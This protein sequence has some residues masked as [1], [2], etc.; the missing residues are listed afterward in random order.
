VGKLLSRWKRERVT[1]N[2]SGENA[3]TLQEF[4]GELGVPLGRVVDQAL[5]EFFQS[6]GVY[7]KPTV[8]PYDMDHLKQTAAE[9]LKKRAQATE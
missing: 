6:V 7:K 8:P 5:D 4:S 2:L 1:T 3:A 9:I